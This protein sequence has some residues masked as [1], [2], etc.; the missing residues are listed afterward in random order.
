MSRRDARD[1]FDYDF[2]HKLS[3]PDIYEKH[4]AESI[5]LQTLRKNRSDS[6]AQSV[7]FS[8]RNQT[9]HPDSDVPEWI[10]PLPDGGKLPEGIPILTP[11]PGEKI[12]VPIGGKTQP[13][14]PISVKADSPK[15]QGILHRMIANFKAGYDFMVP[16]DL[17][18]KTKASV[19]AE[20]LRMQEL[21]AWYKKQ[22]GERRE[23]TV[24]EFMDEQSKEDQ[25]S[26]MDAMLASLG[27]G[28]AA[29]N[30]DPSGSSA[31]A[32][33]PPPRVTPSKKDAEG[34]IGLPDKLSTG[35]AGHALGRA[36]PRQ[37]PTYPL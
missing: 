18:P 20:V 23:R 35:K 1:L 21:E 3:K 34:G 24:L 25:D 9:R 7:W 13:S 5:T 6:V 10:R 30:D 15:A 4:E 33:Q 2:N 27:G 11:E 26:W 29:N 22:E 28:G 31:S 16:A 8:L 19:E 17:S 12:P 32:V 37:P 14:L 36:A